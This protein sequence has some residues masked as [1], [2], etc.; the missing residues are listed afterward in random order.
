[1]TTNKKTGFVRRIFFLFGKIRRFDNLRI[2]FDILNEIAGHAKGYIFHVVYPLYIYAQTEKDS[3]FSVIVTYISIVLGV[4]LLLNIY[5]RWYDEY[6]RLKSDIKIMEGVNR[7]IFSKSA[8]MDIANY[9]NPEFYEKLNRTINNVNE[10][11]LSF[12]DSFFGC[13]FSLLYVLLTAT[14]MTTIDAFVVIF[15][16]V[17][18]IVYIVVGAKINNIKYDYNML[19]QK[20]ERRKSYVKNAFYKKEFSKEIRLTS[21]SKVLLGYFKKAHENSLANAKKFGYKTGRNK[22]VFNLLGRYTIHISAL[23]YITYKAAVA[24]SID[25]GEFYFLLFSIVTLS[26]VFTGTIQNVLK[27]NE[28]SL[29]INDY[30][31]FLGQDSSVSLGNI[32]EIDK[33]SLH[34]EFKNVS[35]KYPGSDIYVLKNIDIEIKEGEKTAFVGYNG[36]GKTTIIKLM[37]RLY[38]PTEGEIL[39]NGID[40]KNFDVDFYRRLFGVVFQ[41]FQVYALSVL[42]NITM[43]DDYAPDDAVKA[44]KKAGILEKINTYQSGIESVMT[45]EFD[46]D[47]IVLSGGEEQKLAI[48]RNFCHDRKVAIFDEP[49]SFLDP[50]AEKMLLKQMTEN[51]KDKIVVFISHRLSSA[52]LADQIFLIDEGHVIER[53]SHEQLM[54]SGGRYKEIFDIQAKNYIDSQN[55]KNAEEA[56]TF[57]FQY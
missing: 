23:V 32:K 4:Y 10:R 34:I 16:F 3:D 45:K 8:Q 38:D 56:D 47:G 17:P 55:S 50:Y 20:E 37:L 27:I 25:V 11:F 21:I 19:Q 24:K 43:G 7:E 57:D 30:I 31:D 46:N 54:K 40:I 28:D 5:S 15:V 22:A 14:I 1:M 51:Q 26:W 2:F 6:Y 48:A 39:L 35:F 52:T 53:G 18:I 29:Y 12:K 42:D 33:N 13:I 36:A 44:A 9:E 41:D 49:S